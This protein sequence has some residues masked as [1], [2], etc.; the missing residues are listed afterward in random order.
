M[1]SSVFKLY[2]GIDYDF[3]PESFWE[4]AP[5]PLAAIL[6]NIKGRRRRE[7]IRDHYAAGKLDELSNELLN[8]SLDEETR[9]RLGQIH[10][11]F[12]GG[13]YLPDYRRREVEIVRIELK[14]T[15]SDVISLRAR[16]SG[17]RIKYRLVDENDL[18]FFLPQQSSKRPFS[19]RELISFL[20]SVEHAGGDP[21]WHA[22]GFMLSFN[23][24]NFEG[25][26]ALETLWSF[27][28]VRS[29]FYPGLASHYNLSID[30]WYSTRE[31]NGVEVLIK[32]SLAIHEESYGSEHP[33]V[34]GD[35]FT[36]GRLLKDEGRFHQAEPLLRRA[37]IILLKLT[38]RRAKRHIHLWYVAA[39]Y[40]TVLEKLSL[41]KREIRQRLDQMRT[42]TG[43]DHHTFSELN[44]TFSELT[45]E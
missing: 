37:L 10:P 22:F 34:A 41:N 21:A 17:S 14:S 8:E 19:L 43:F 28:S 15:T 1:K 31:N 11:S 25:G 5:D 44:H 23:E 32:N 9:S 7:M 38:K 39:H 12:M 4:T 42:E 30:D 45:R 27:T 16:S 36:L 13:E 3:R 33:K 18:G 20:D 2:S 6:R 35:L 29:D 24:I 26:S 40:R